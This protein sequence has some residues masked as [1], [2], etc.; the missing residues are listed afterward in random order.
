MT[1]KFSSSRWLMVA[2]LLVMVIG[3][4]VGYGQEPT[5]PQKESP[6]ATT[7]TQKQKRTKKVLTV[8][9][10]TE[11]TSTTEATGNQTTA[12]VSSG[13]SNNRCGVSD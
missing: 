12:A 10:S 11:A 4:G 1:T 5:A 2:T 7:P 9:K 3:F 13:A 6:K 8:P